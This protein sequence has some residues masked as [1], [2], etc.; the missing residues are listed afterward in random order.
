M[1]GSTLLHEIP[2]HDYQ[3]RR[4]QLRCD[5]SKEFKAYKRNVKRSKVVC[6]IECRV[7]L[8]QLEMSKARANK[9]KWVAP[10]LRTCKSCSLVK[11]YKDDFPHGKHTCKKCCNIGRLAYYYNSFKYSEE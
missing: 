4:Y 1:I 10:L 9:V 7:K 6:C 3:G 2:G 5:C 11:T 8:K